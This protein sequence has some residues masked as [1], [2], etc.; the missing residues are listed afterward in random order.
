VKELSADFAVLFGRSGPRLPGPGWP[1]PVCDRLV[2]RLRGRLWA[3]RVKTAA[4][5]CRT[6]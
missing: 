4:L 1:V 3:E 5:L 2:R 6:P